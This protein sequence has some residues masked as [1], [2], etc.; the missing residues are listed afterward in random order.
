MK[1][2]NALDNM[3]Q[4]C[5]KCEVSEDAVPEI[6]KCKDTLH[7]VDLDLRTVRGVTYDTR[8]LAKRVLILFDKSVNGKNKKAGEPLVASDFF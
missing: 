4:Y 2:K 5:N 8:E 1:I 3:I 7:D 6:K